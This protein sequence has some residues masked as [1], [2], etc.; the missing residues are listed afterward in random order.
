M[1][2]KPTGRPPG[3]PRKHPVIIRGERLGPVTVSLRKDPDRFFLAQYRAAKETGNSCSLITAIAYG[4]RVARADVPS[5]VRAR[6][7]KKCH[8]DEVTL[9]F[10]AK[11]DS[12][13]A[14]K[15]DGLKTDGPTKAS[16]LA[17]LQNL[18]RTAR[19]K[20]KDVDDGNDVDDKHWLDNMT[21][22]ISLAMRAPAIFRAAEPGNVRLVQVILK[23]QA[24][25]LALDSREEIYAIQHIF[26]AIDAAAEKT[27]IAAR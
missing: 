12:L 23:G 16:R 18:Q 15:T 24:L 25:C 1:V 14:V 6:V 22:A 2:T 13:K 4:N 26:P 11:A 7:A 17:T 3:R 10:R 27:L 9:F 19:K 5:R 20:L 8:D 21:N